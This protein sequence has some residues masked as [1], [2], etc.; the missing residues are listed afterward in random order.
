VGLILRS[1]P[2]PCGRPGYVARLEAHSA[3]GIARRQ[4][5]TMV[6]HVCRVQAHRSF[7]FSERPPGGR[8]F[9]R[10]TDREEE[11]GT[12]PSEAAGCERRCARIDRI[13]TSTPHVG[14]ELRPATCAVADTA[15]AERDRPE[16]GAGSCVARVKGRPNK[17]DPVRRARARARARAHRGMASRWTPRG[18][19][20]L[21]RDRGGQ[22]RGIDNVSI[23]YLNIIVLKEAITFAERI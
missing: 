20:W 3:G 19:R 10:R 5:R 14:A 21:H 8:P 18:V 13:A 17:N 9:R 15:R 22:G 16:G 11:K 12:G 23:Y 7:G 2:T 1:P 4:T 6:C